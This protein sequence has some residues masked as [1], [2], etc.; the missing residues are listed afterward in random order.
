[1]CLAVVALDVHPRYAT[2]VAANRDEY[3]ARPAG[4]AHWWNDAAGFALLAGRDLQQGGT[5]LGVTRR[6]RWAFVTNV[7]EP[8]RHDP[9]AP[10]RG[11]LVPA[12]LRDPHDVRDAVETAIVHAAACNGFNLVAGAGI[13]AV[14]G[15]NRTPHVQSLG[16]GIHGVSNA[17]LDTPWPKLARA[18]AGVAAWVARG[19]LDLDPLFDVLADRA[20]AP[21]AELPDTGITRERE[22]LLSAPFFVSADYGTRCSTVLALTRDGHVHLVERSFDAGGEI[23]G[24]VEYGFDVAPSTPHP[25]SAARL[26]PTRGA[27]WRE[28][29]GRPR[30]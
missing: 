30:R 11:A 6:G 1:V 16:A 22:R 18:K 4:R 21:D 9:R 27:G 26:A 29:H 20:S 19:S 13:G 3:H 2:V 5:W 8:G 10:S 28:G 15:S 24:D 14:F 7:R 12:V 17:Q 23:T 25:P